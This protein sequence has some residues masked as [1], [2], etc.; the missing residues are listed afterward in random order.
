M[1]F[2]SL[3]NTADASFASGCIYEGRLM[4]AILRS[5]KKRQH[6]QILGNNMPC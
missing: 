4:S 3:P 5:T 2:G 6:A 1:T